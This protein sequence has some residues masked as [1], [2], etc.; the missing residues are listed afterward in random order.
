MIRTT[1]EQKLE[2][3]QCALI[4]VDMQNDYIHP[5]GSAGRR[6]SDV[7][8]G[9]DVVPYVNRLIDAARRAGVLVIYT[10]NW[11]GPL[12]D[13]EVWLERT[14]R[15]GTGMENRA[16]LVGS[17][18]ADW[19]GVQPIEGEIILN[20]FRYDAFLGTNLEYILRA[21]GI[22]S[23]VACGTATNVC[24]ESTVRA[25]HMRDYYVVL[26]SDCCAA[27]DHVLHNATL[28]N[29]DRHFGV[30]ATGAEIAACWDAAAKDEKQAVA[31][32]T[33]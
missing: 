26:A 30:I 21:K 24:V 25:A 8:T 2:P 15:A 23:I 16:G 27:F 5:Q 28:S 18:G 4:V 13:T 1:L 11:H 10:R 3:S 31:A 14:V 32:A 19:Y 6:G 20:K 12:T 22:E 33:A 17:W 7:Q 9:I 29:V